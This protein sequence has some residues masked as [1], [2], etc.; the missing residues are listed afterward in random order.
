VD[1]YHE[2]ADVR[3]VTVAVGLTLAI[4]AGAPAAVAAAADARI[5]VLRPG[6]CPVDLET[7]RTVECYRLRLPQVRSD[8]TQG[9]VDIQVAI[10]RAKNPM[11]DPILFVMGGPDYPGVDPFST[12][13]LSG[14]EFSRNRDWILFDARG[15]GS[16][17][18]YLGCSEIDEWEVDF[19]PENQGP[20][21]RHQDELIAAHRAC[22]RRLT[23]AGAALRSY[24]AFDVARDIIDLRIALGV[25]EWNVVS[26]SAGGEAT[27]ELMR[28]DAAPI[29]SVILDSPVTRALRPSFDFAEYGQRLLQRVLRKCAQQSDC[30][31]AYPDLARRFLR[32][33]HRLNAHP[34]RAEIGLA[35]GGTVTWTI[36]GMIL[37]DEAGFL[38][39]NPSDARSL[40]GLIDSFAHGHA[41]DYFEEIVLEP[42]GPRND[43]FAEGRTR[44]A[45][46]RENTSFETK[47][48]LN[49]VQ[50][51]L[52]SV[53]PL[54]ADFY[55]TEHRIC[56]A[57]HVGQSDPAGYG[58]LDSDLPV[59][60][61]RGEWDNA[62]S[63][64]GHILGQARHFPNGWA[65]TFPDHGHIQ[66]LDFGGDSSCAASIAADF[67]RNPATSPDASCIADMPPTVF[68]V[69]DH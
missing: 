52:L 47:R 42:E 6:P 31:A 2:V 65:F 21:A 11:P 33:V 9:S 62:P 37:L 57:W 19:F 13:Y 38:A 48:T 36:D 69:G 18:P 23:D 34:L 46:C 25:A 50:E 61:L 64:D 17:K 60:T 5:G 3:L 53:A 39:G 30:A 10:A 26:L 51:R 56:D 1:F 45:R 20:Q 12:F 7:K 41:L 63:D 40:P 29:R 68:E 15:T 66:L 49:A 27:L 67:I 58:Y 35:G 32:E 44:A 43:V 59:L 28:L 55:A 24:G 8:A 16:S 54:L 14:K 4:F 22:R